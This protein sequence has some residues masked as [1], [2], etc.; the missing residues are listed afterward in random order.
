[1]NII[2][3]SITSCPVLRSGGRAGARRGRA[4][5]LAGGLRVSA[6]PGS[7]EGDGGE[8]GGERK[9]RWSAHPAEPERQGQVTL[10][11]LILCSVS[12]H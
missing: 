3:D 11:T 9:L 8:D 5:G 12:S 10:K 4:D 7:G 1:M 2:A 6:L